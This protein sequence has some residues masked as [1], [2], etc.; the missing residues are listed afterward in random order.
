MR[1]LWL[2]AFLWLCA[3]LQG[4]G[5][6]QSAAEFESTPEVAFLKATVNQ[7]VT[8]QHGAIKALIDPSVQHPEVD[9]ALKNLQ[10]KVPAGT[11]THLEAVNWQVM[12]TTQIAGRDGSTRVA[13][14][15]FEYTYPGP[16]WMIASASL[17]GEPGQFR[18]LAFNIEPIPAPLSELNAFSLMNK[19]WKHYAF[20]VMALGAFS[21]SLFA[22]LRCIRTQDLKSKWLWA[23]F[24]CVGLVAFSINWTSGAISIKPLY[25]SFMSASIGQSGWVGPWI[26]SFS[27]PVGALAFLAAQALQKKKAAASA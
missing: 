25:F 7:L 11:P 4:C 12:R 17:A 20:L 5:L 8:H 21:V 3:S 24:I 15:A 23:V 13:N 6:P 14:V 10:A 16:R 2:A 19:S 9:S 26:V 22:L 18:I 1:A 27:V